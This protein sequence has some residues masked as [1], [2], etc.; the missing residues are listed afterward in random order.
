MCIQCNYTVPLFRRMPFTLFSVLSVD[1]VIRYCPSGWCLVK[2]KLKNSSPLCESILLY[3]FSGTHCAVDMKVR[4]KVHSPHRRT[5]NPFRNPF[6]FQ[7]KPFLVPGRTLSQRILHG[8]QKSSTWNQKG[9][10][11]EPKGVLLWVQP[12][13]RIL[14]YWAI[15][16]GSL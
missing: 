1:K 9:F 3:R 5:L 16:L 6:W 12:N 13:N 14:Q 7:V 15:A 8:T 10:Y 4:R 11:L 2:T